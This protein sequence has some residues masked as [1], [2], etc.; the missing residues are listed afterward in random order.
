[1]L[2]DTV[3]IANRGEIACRVIRTLRQ[4]NIRSVAIYSDA[5]AGALHVELADESHRIGPPPASQSYLDRDRII[6]LA[7]RVGAQAIHPGYGFLSE[8]AAFAEACENAGLIFIGP[9]AEVIRSMGEKSGAKQKM[10]EVGIPV[11]PGHFDSDQD[12]LRLRGAADALGY[13]L[14]VKAVAGGGGRGMRVVAGGED[15][16]S[17][18]AAARREAEGAF[19]DDRMLLE[20][21]VAP[22]RHVE[23]QIFGDSHGNVVHLFERDCSLQRRHQKVIEEAPAPGLSDHFRNQLGDAAVR[24]ARAIGYVGA[25]TVE[26]LIDVASESSGGSRPFY[27]M[28][29]NTRLQVEHPVSEMV[30]G[31]D[32]VEWQ[33]RIAAGEVLPLSQD[34]IVLSG[35]SIETRICAEDPDA[36]FLPTAGH[37]AHLSKPPEGDELRVETGVSPGDDVSVHYDSMIAKL[38]VWGA[39]RRAALARLRGALAVFQLAGFA[40]NLPFLY[41]AVQHPDFEAGEFDTGFIEARGADLIRRPGDIPDRILALAC[42]EAILVRQHRAA[43]TRRTA[44]VRSPWDAVD[45][46]RINLVAR[47]EMLFESDGQSFGAE[48]LFLGEG[49]YRVS[50]PGGERVVSGCSEAWSEREAGEISV[51]RFEADLSESE[52]AVGERATVTAVQQG[53]DLTLFIE[54]EVYRLRCRALDGRAIAET[55]SAGAIVT[56]MPGKI[57]QVAVAVGDRVAKGQSLVVLEAMKMEHNVCAPLDSV[58]EKLDVEIGDQVEEGKVLLV[59]AAD[60]DGDDCS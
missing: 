56:P 37:I 46:F 1:M 17:A 7:R 39:D 43:S 23:V 15:F 30:T 34:Q 45:S 22:A 18:L 52:G 9:S 36:G 25:G 26:F 28:E 16:A 8:N 3:L 54:G 49:R 10:A 33:I 21:L 29:M 20:K 2:I 40:T 35:H 14:L 24:A 53:I 27:F 4:M 44:D 11:V 57:I 55:E 47:E 59:L 12:P 51:H 31:L 42:L 50:L 5:D 41:R 48:V 13:P 19:G 6:E 38:V 58:V 60:R 32:F